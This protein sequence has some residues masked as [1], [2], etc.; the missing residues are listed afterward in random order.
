VSF[1]FL[2]KEANDNSNCRVA[3]QVTSDCSTKFQKNW[4][5][6]TDYCP[7]LKFRNAL[8]PEMLQEGSYGYNS[9]LDDNFFFPKAGHFM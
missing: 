9:R 3:N 8:T 5:K 6:K 1:L 4:S 7:I 2:V